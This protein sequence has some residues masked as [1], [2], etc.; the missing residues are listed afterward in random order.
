MKLIVKDRNSMKENPCLISDNGKELK[1]DAIPTPNKLFNTLRAVNVKL[2]NLMFLENSLN[3]W[4]DIL[5]EKQ[6]DRNN[7]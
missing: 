6:N 5:S 7:P 4:A 3:N 1:E 2:V